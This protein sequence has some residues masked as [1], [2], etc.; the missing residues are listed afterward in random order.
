MILGNGMIARAMWRGKAGIADEKNRITG[1]VLLDLDNIT[2]NT[3]S[4]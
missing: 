2:R 3:P 1:G 4:K